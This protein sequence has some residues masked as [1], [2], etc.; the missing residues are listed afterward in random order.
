[1]LQEGMVGGI[2]R[3]LLYAWPSLKSSLGSPRLLEL[4]LVSRYWL[5][6]WRH[7]Q[8][9]DLGVQLPVSQVLN[10]HLG[11]GQPMKAM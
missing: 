7:G 3:N 10:G 4:E 11:P 9:L 1:M 5:P 2:I 6:Q 8:S